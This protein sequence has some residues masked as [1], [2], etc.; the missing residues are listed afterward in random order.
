MKVLFNLFV[1]NVYIE[2]ENIHLIFYYLR[3]NSDPSGRS[4][5]RCYF[6]TKLGN[7]KKDNHCLDF[8]GMNN[9]LEVD[10]DKL[11][12][13]CEPRVSMGKDYGRKHTI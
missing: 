13:L 10:E 1:R 8:S 7:L 2:S 5:K 6:E 11:E 9:I 12:I 3:Y 4:F